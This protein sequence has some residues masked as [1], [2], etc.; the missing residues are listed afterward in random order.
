MGRY[1]LTIGEIKMP[2]NT[3]LLSQLYEQPKQESPVS[4]IMQSLLNGGQQAGQQSQQ[5]WYKTKGGIAGISGL[6]S[7]IL[8]GLLGAN[9]P[10]ALAY[11]TIGSFK[12]FRYF[13]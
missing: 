3:E 6:T 7:S 4:N 2:F 13:G 8:S 11:G 5:P 1:G 12:R 9:V 10:E